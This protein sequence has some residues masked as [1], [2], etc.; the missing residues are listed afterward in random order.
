MTGRASL[1]LAALGLAGLGFAAFASPAPR[2]VWNASAS[3]PLGLYWVTHAPIGR[4]DFVLAEPPDSARR[5]AAAR[6]YLPAHVRLVKRVAG[7]AGDTICAV[8]NVVLINGRPAADRLD[9]DSRGRPLP[10]W[11]GCRRLGPDEVFLLMEDVPDSF[12]G[13]Y[14]GPIQRRTVVGKLLPLWTFWPERSRRREGAVSVRS[15]HNE[16]RP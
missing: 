15:L 8:G 9:D 16:L 1:V 5:L 10:A 7:L 2:L 12:D 6:G 3:A 14:F 4:G 11:H 13:R